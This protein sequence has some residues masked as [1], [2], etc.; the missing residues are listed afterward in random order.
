MPLTK[1]AGVFI[2]CIRCPLLVKSGSAKTTIVYTRFLLNCFCGALKVNSSHFLF[3]IF[4]T[5]YRLR[6]WKI[7]IRYV[8]RSAYLR[9]GYDKL[10]GYQ[11]HL[12][13]ILPER[14]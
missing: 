4:K 8:F 12:S 1:G 7:K 13:A 11:Y 10:F 3:F 2:V 6:F 5:I 14:L 9:N